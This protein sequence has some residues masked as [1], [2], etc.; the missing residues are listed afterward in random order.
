MKN[1]SKGFS[2]LY[3]DMKHMCFTLIELLVVIAII[4]ILAGMLLPALNNARESGRKA[5]CIN[6]LKQMHLVLTTYSAN[7]DDVLITATNGTRYWGHVL[8]VGGA[9]KGIFETSENFYPEIMKC[10]S[11]P[12]LGNTT[13]QLNN[14]VYCYAINQRVSPLCGTDKYQLASSYT[15]LSA[16]K[17][18]S[19]VSWLGDAKSGYGYTWNEN[20]FDKRI[21]WRHGGR[22]NFLYVDGHVDSN[23]LAYYQMN[24]GTGSRWWRAFFN[25]HGN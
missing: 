3:S 17:N 8:L 25:W 14:G 7:Y 24:P 9:F 5:S 16:V 23:T 1:A 21:G 6:N 4:A 15:K 13:F 19:G 11:D 22:A 18:P 20:E 12:R 10:K 2:C